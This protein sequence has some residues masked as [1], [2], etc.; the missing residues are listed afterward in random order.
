MEDK[1]PIAPTVELHCHNMSPVRIETIIGRLGLM[2][3]YRTISINPDR[4]RPVVRRR[5]L[6]VDCNRVEAGQLM[7]RR[8]G[9]G[10]VDDQHSL[11]AQGSEEC[12]CL[13]A[14]AHGAE[15]FE[16]PFGREPVL[17]RSW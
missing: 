5:C 14:G 4:G 11:D 3:R 9:P 1:A 10:P 13:V 12:L 7:H 15:I 6:D 2:R 8:L 16:Q 17:Y